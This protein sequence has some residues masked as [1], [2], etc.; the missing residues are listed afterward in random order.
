VENIGFVGM[1]QND[2]ILYS[3]QVHAAARAAI[4]K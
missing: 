4:Y 2:D 3:L 1:I